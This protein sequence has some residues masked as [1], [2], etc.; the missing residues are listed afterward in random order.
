MNEVE[1]SPFSGCTPPPARMGSEFI[2]VVKVQDS[3]SNL[4]PSVS[5]A[6]SSIVTVYFF[7]SSYSISGLNVMVLSE[8]VHTIN[9]EDEP[10]ESVDP[11]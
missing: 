11:S 4:I 1:V 2:F 10:K 8:L 7:P 3:P 5:S 9:P 6:V